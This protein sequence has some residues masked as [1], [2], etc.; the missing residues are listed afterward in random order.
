[1]TRGDD[2]GQHDESARADQVGRHHQP[3]AVDPVG[4]HAGEQAEQHP[5]QEPRRE[6]AGRHKRIVGEQGRHQRQSDDRHAVGQV[7]G[8]AADPEPGERPAERRP[9]IVRHRALPSRLLG[10]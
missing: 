4:D 5:R 8:Q 7:A 3:G 6:Q 2:D 9:A 1:V 10:A